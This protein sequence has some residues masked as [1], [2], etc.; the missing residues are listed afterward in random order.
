ML[1]HSKVC[2][3]GLCRKFPRVASR[4]TWPENR[5]SAGNLAPRAGKY[6]AEARR[7]LA[8]LSRFTN[9]A[10]QQ[11]YACNVRAQGLRVVELCP[12]PIARQ[13]A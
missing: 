3:Q 2:G 11:I 13:H 12:W 8:S 5:Q 6:T 9:Q 10:I 1:A 4:P 7:Q